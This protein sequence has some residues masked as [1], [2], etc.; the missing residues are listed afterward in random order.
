MASGFLV[1]STIL[2]GYV[3]LV[4]EYG[5]DA[6]EFLVGASIDSSR[7]EDKDYFFPYVNFTELL[8]VT[9]RELIRPDFGLRFSNTQNYEILGPIAFLVL[10]SLNIRSG[11]LDVARYLYHLSPSISLFIQDAGG[12]KV[13]LDILNAGTPEPPMA[14][15][16]HI[17]ATFNILKEINGGSIQAEKVSFRHKQL[18]PTR[19]YDE[20]FQCP[21][22]FLQPLNSISIKKAFIDN[23]IP[24]ANSDLH[25]LVDDY[26]RILPSHSPMNCQM[27]LSDQVTQLILKLMPSGRITRTAIAE[28]LGLNERVLHRNLKKE[29]CTYESLVESARL[30]SVERLLRE[31][32]LPMSQISGLLGYSEQSSFNR[33]FKRWFGVSPKHYL[34]EL[35]DNSL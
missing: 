13:G 20:V 11:I 9:A 26:L 27:L 32:Q 29:N 4:S 18:A 28:K 22:E 5:G 12:P 8:E 15:E 16:H 24:T 3:E 14:V 21:V 1:R 7:I 35:N 31:N 17:G 23:Q 10:S 2:A 30:S 33:A 19:V 6:T 25:A 34:R